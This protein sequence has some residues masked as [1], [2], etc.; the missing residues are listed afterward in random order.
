MRRR[1][2]REGRE[3]GDGGL[4]RRGAVDRGRREGALRTLD[5][6]YERYPANREILRVLSGYNRQMGRTKAAD[7]YAAELETIGG[8]R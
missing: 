3:E 1:I 8:G 2:L 7:R 4:S 6:L 5:G